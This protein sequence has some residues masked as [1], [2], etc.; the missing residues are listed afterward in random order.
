MKLIYISLQ[1][2]M[3]VYMKTEF[4]ICTILCYIFHCNCTIISL[5]EGS[6]VIVFP[7][8]FQGFLNKVD[9]WGEK[10]WTKY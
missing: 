1:L 5:F 9:W 2:L 6:Q 3:W 4:M 8:K 10:I 7:I